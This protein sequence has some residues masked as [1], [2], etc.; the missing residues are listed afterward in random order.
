MQ[1][2]NHLTI[3]SRYNAEPFIHYVKTLSLSVSTALKITVTSGSTNGEY[4]DSEVT[5][6]TGRKVPSR[7][8][9]AKPWVSPYG[10]K[11]K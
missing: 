3:S 2:D 9:K 4:R 5:T 10:G 11:R 8:P 1:F 7:N 6:S